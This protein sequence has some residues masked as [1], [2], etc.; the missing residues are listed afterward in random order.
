MARYSVT[1]DMISPCER[2]DIET[3]RLMEDLANQIEA[4]DLELERLDKEW[5]QA[6][7]VCDL[8][9]QNKIEDHY[10]RLIPQREELQAQYDR[11]NTGED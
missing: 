9:T 8:L 3:L 6:D 4:I 1:P 5:E 10:E 7:Q 11:A 2:W